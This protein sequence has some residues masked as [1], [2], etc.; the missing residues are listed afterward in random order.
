MLQKMQNYI[1][2]HHMIEPGD[3][4]VVGVSGGADSVCLLLLLKEYCK[5]CPITLLGVHMN[6][7]IREEA[8]EDAD[9]VKWLCTQLEVPFYL[10]EEDVEEIAKKEKISVEEAGRNVRYAAFS[11]IIQDQC[12][13]KGKIAVAHH[14]GDRAETMLFHMF[15]GSGI[16]GMA[17]ILPVRENIIRPILCMSRAEIEAYLKK[18][19]IS[20]CIDSTNEEDTYTRNKIRN[21]LLPF[22]ESEILSGATE[23]LASEAEYILEVKEYIDAQT[24]EALANVAVCE[25]KRVS[26]DVFMFLQLS[27]FIQR[28]VLLEILKNILPKRKDMTRKHI[29][30]V[31]ELF[32][33][34]G[35]KTASLPYGLEGKKEYEKVVI[36]YQAEC[37]EGLEEQKVHV[38]EHFFVKMLGNVETR[39]FS[40]ENIENIP[41]NIYTKWFDYD[42]ISHCLT[43]RKRQI[44]D[45]FMINDSLQRKTIKSYMIQ[46]KIPQSMRNQLPLFADQDHILW[47][48]GY[49]MSAYYKVS[50]D[51]KQILEIKIKSE[52]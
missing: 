20:W 26:I 9:Y 44:G 18:E 17:G 38:G 49:R 24:K 12:G 14:Q 34:E 46:E 37:E 3:H 40:N 43:L 27:E 4:I 22:V 50:K 6:H 10:F 7:L 35:S 31:Q 51:T 41:Q 5:H 29:L 42:K 21:Q 8:S 2:K 47:I 32:W 16:A 33:K 13:G 1:E 23:H 25:K 11:K 36:G 48:P 52:N 19:K 45:F 30:Q 39:V 28:E 15:R